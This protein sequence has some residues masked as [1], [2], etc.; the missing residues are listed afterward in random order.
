MTKKIALLAKQKSSAY[1]HLIMV[2][3]SFMM[4]V[5]SVEVQMFWML[6]LF[7]DI[8]GDAVEVMKCS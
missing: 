4:V 2:S 6:T 7:Y 5:T 3:P 8:V 1:V